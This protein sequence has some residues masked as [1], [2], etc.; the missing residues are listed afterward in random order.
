MI[1]ID[2]PSRRELLNGAMNADE[3]RERV[4]PAT[5]DTRAPVTTISSSMLGSASS[6]IQTTDRALAADIGP[7]RYSIVG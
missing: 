3:T 4:A 5:H 2:I 6:R 7:W 1:G